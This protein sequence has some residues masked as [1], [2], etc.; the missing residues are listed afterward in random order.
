[1]NLLL[2]Y[3][4][5]N[6]LYLFAGIVAANL[7][8]IWLSRS[9]LINEIVFYNTY[10]EQL[11][12]ERSIQLFERMNNM[13]WITYIFT[14]V[15]LLIKFSVVSLLIYTGIIFCNI[16]D[17]VSLGSVFKVVIASEVVFVFGSLLKFLW[18]ILFG[19]NYDL[20]DLGFFYP[21]SIINFFNPSE[22]SKVWIYPLQTINL[23]HIGYI[24]SIS[25]GINK[26]C[27]IETSKSEK[28]VLVSYLPGLA[29]W[30]SLMMFL[31][32]DL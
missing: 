31:T 30:I 22:V 6:R 23:F 28:A 11:T 10:S 13:A 15:I 17:R 27:S 14:P 20:N 12:Y 26:V 7:L 29:L 2:R 19:G 16:E 21:L 25:V 24:I 3:Y 18:F 8:L 32:I 9:L 1:M 4:S 5:L